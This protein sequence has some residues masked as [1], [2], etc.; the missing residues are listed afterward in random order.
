MPPKAVYDAYFSGLPGRTGEFLATG[1]LGWHAEAGIHLRMALPGAFD[2]H[3]NLTIV[4]GHM[5]E[6]LPF[7][8]DRADRVLLGFRGFDRPVSSIITKHVYITTRG[9]FS[10]PPFLNALLTFGADRILFSVDYPYS[11]KSA[12]RSFL[13]NLP[14]SAADK[15]MISYRNAERILNLSSA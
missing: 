2:R 7:M 14:V 4:L 12:G 13:E 10:L 15:A 5:G 11:P 6:V 1:V 9:F 8:L 3:L